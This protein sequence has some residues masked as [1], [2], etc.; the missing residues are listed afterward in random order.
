MQTFYQEIIDWVYLSGK[1]LAEKSGSVEDIGIKKQYLTEEDLRIERELYEKIK[2]YNASHELFSEEEHEEYFD[3][4]DVWICDPISGTK[5]FISGEAPFSIAISHVHKGEIVFA[6]VYAPMQ[7]ELFIAEKGKG[8][9][10][11]GKQLHISEDSNTILLG[12]GSFWEEKKQPMQELLKNEG[13][14]IDLQK[15]SQAYG[16][17]MLANGEFGG[18]IFF[19]KDN[20][21]IFA[22]ALLVTE[23]GGKITNT[24]GKTFFQPH[25]KIFIAGNSKNQN[26]LQTLV[27]T[28]LFNEQ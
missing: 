21:P 6:V 17:G 2:K 22:G 16:L 5:Y 20:F 24:E 18:V 19:G 4:E 9:F 28:I 23:A 15:G 8:S 26:H 10:L 7:D 11:N 27:Q 14:T 1:R 13:Y 3:T 25:D 12:M